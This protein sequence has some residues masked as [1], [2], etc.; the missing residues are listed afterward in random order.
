MGG[1]LIGLTLAL[2]VGFA[3]AQAQTPLSL[4][5]TVDD[6][7]AHGPLPPGVSRLDLARD[8]IAALETAKV[9]A[10]GFVNG[11]FGADDPDAPRV[12]AAWRKAGLPLGDHGFSHFDLD[13]VA[14]STFIA[15]LAR[16]KPFVTGQPAR[17]RYPFLH[18]GYDPAKRDA[19]RAALAQR[20][21]RI[22]A[23][24]LSFDDYAYN[25][26]YVRC[27]AQHDQAAVAALEARY[28]AAA[29]ADAERA[30]AITAATLHRDVPHVL[31]LHIGAFGAHMMPR[32]LA[33]YRDM[34]FAFV[35]LDTAQAD[36]FYAAADPA[37]PGPTPTMDALARTMASPPPKPS[38]PGDDVC[39]ARP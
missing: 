23:V 21:Y 11:S 16:N 8:M 29:R 5:V 13:S 14:A 22:A 12:L 1:R 39:L 15:D 38:L 28:L 31:L 3:P 19:V 25:A 32:L 20:H 2:L 17:F 10:T 6:L 7:P 24:T 18:E 37:T 4:A 30:R 35:P 9:P 26:P 27:L 36:P 33:L 34:G